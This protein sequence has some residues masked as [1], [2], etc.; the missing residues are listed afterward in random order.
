[1]QLFLERRPG[2]VIYLIAGYCLLAF[3]MRL[4]R[5]EALEID[6]AEQAFLSQYLFAGFGTQPPFYNWLQFLLAHVFGM[7]VATLA[8]LK[9]ALLF[10]CLF[11]YYRAARIVFIGKEAAAIAALAC[12]TFPPVFLLIQRDLS[13]TVAAL[14]TVALFLFAFLKCLERP[15]LGSYLLAGLAVGLGIISKYNFVVIPIA[16]VIAILPEADLRKRV[17]DWRFAMA[18]VIAVIVVTPHALWLLHNLGIATGGT[19]DEMKEGSASSHT[20]AWIKGIISY[21]SAAVSVVIPTLILFFLAFHADRKAIWTAR[22]LWTRIFGRMLLICLALVLLVV[23]LTGATHIREKWLILFV[24]LLPLYLGAKVDAANID[25]KAK[26]SKFASLVGLVAVGAL[27]VLLLSAWL[28]PIFGSYSRLN[29]PYRAFSQ[30]I[31]REGGAPSWILTADRIV[32]GNMRIQFPQV[33]VVL[34]SYDDHRQNRNLPDGSGLIVWTD[35]DINGNALPPSIQ[36]Y[37]SKNG[38]SPQEV[39]PQFVELPYKPSWGKGRFRFAYARV[40]ASR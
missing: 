19:L 4:L 37:L 22:S 15:N 8:L 12:L 40:S 9:D 30:D 10:L 31:V 17:L 5:S 6:E 39:K 36:A 38:L 29:V 11:F 20:P 24:F 18:I 25:V 16:A 23:L 26:L 33:P 14:F 27:L 3:L 13:H 1:M 35:D 21:T 32:A 2:R 28:G 7:S 34:P